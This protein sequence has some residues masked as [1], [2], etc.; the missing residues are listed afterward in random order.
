MLLLGSRLNNTPVM[1]LQTGSE[2]ARAKRAIIDPANLK[3][4]AYVVNS[5]LLGSTDR[6]LRTADTRELSDIG[7]IVDSI[8]EL[9][10]PDDVI[11]LKDLIEKNFRLLG[12]KVLNEKRRTIGKVYDYNIDV[13]SFT[14]IQ[15]IVKRPLVQRINESDLVVHRSQIIEITDDSIVIQSEAK[16]PEYTRLNTPGAYVNPFRKEEP[17]AE[18]ID[19]ID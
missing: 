16:V 10:Q 11:K 5:P 4:T 3:V 14:V 8:D 6:L 7:L 13:D 9:V 15:L 19:I 18:S 17:A 2:V 1:S 12:I